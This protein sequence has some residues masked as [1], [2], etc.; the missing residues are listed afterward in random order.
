[1]PGSVGATTLSQLVEGGF[2]GRVFPVN[3]RHRELC[4]L[5]CYPSLAE[6]PGPVDLAVISVS[7]RGLEAQM[8]LAAECGAKSA[9]IYASA[10]E[11]AERDGPKLTERITRIALRA[12]MPVCGAN[13]MGFVNPARSL[14]VCGYFLPCELGPGPIAFISHAGATFS[15]LLHNNRGLRFNLAVSPGQELS[16]TAADY[17]SYSVGL[18]GTRVVGLLLEQIRDPVGF[19]SGVRLAHERGVAV[20]VLKIG[21]DQ[22][23]R[24]LIEAHSGALAG[25]DGAYEAFFETHGI[26]RVRTIQEL[27]DTLELFAAPRRAGRGGLA[28]VTDSGGERAL[29]VDLAGHV[30]FGEPDGQTTARLT[31]LLD[32][33]LPPINPLDAWGTGAD[34]DRVFA[35]TLRTLHDDED[36]AAVLFAVDLTGR[37]FDRYADI[38]VET[39]C[40]T[41]KPIAVLTHF[42]NGMNR[43]AASRIRDADIPLLEGTA[44]GLAA[45][46]HLLAERDNSVLTRLQPP[47]GAPSAI[48]ERWSQRLADPLDLSATE[49]L[50][51]VADWDIP[52]ARTEVAVDEEGAVEAAARIGWPVAL[53]T[54]MSDIAHKTDVSGV[55]LR[56]EGPDSLRQAYRDI[57]GRLGPNVAVQAM[58]PEGIELALGIVHDNTF[59]PIVV[60]GAGG[61]LVELLN[62]RRLAL[63]PLDT[64]RARRLVDGLRARALLDGVR[65]RP[66]VDVDAVLRVVV[67]LSALALDLGAQLAALDINPL[68]ATERGCLAVD[69]FVVRSRA[70]KGS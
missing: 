22:R 31:S 40:A 51:L 34:A 46:G 50:A 32:P 7:N 25:S 39:A 9:V 18:E 42:P 64:P 35:Q 38:S 11:E 59:G 6:V 3:P 67:R 20:V 36:T 17:L 19:A 52:V 55:S 44:T 33:G 43:A 70:S 62:D 45:I 60:V 69:C 5:P 16:M 28:A 30:S 12:G 66:A 4:G 57:A 65:G 56:L 21:A 47:P 14:R 53:K 24:A 29:L 61:T 49:A 15:A 54:A 27:A 8:E 41:T 68:I 37:S 58:A 23:S 2:G 63:P 48:R 26:H 1:M 13:C 10:F